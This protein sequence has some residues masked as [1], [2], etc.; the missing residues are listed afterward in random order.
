M[1]LE[2]ELEFLE[3]RTRELEHT[4][5]QLEVDKRVLEAKNSTLQ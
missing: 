4:N 1:D 2:D 3:S 5:Q